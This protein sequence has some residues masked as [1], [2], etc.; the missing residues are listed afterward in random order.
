MPSILSGEE[1]DAMDSGDES[2]DEP[3]FTKMLEDIFGGSQY[4]P[5]VNRIESCYKIHDHIRAGPVLAR[6]LVD[7]RPSFIGA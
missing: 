6:T 3:I 2:E 1:M 5:S 7:I 4:H